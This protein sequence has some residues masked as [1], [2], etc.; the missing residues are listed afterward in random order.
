MLEANII[1]RADRYANNWVE[2]YKMLFS[3]RLTDGVAILDV[4]SGRKPAILPEERPANSRYVGLD[5]SQTELELALPGSYDQMVVADLIEFQPQL[6][7]SFDLIVS[8]QVLEHVSPLQTAV[9]NVRHYL[10]DG[11]MFVSMLAGGNAYFSVLNRIVP[12]RAGKLAME[13]LLHRE[14]DTV[15]R[16]HCLN[17][18]YGM[19]AKGFDS[20]S[21]VRFLPGYKGVEYL[22]FAPPWQHVFL[23]CEDWV[24]NRDKRDLATHSIV[25]ATK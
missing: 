25:I 8:W 3:S 20:W 22:Q 17:C 12:E 19:L 4:G 9:E 16:A 23:K 7:N 11:G 24:A 10:T 13:R 2:S 14:P 18:T 1:S 21:E 15:F 6:E 5:I